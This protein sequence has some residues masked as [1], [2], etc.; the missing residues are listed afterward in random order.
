V[1]LGS[2]RHNAVPVRPCNVWTCV[3]ALRVFIKCSQDIVSAFDVA[4][5][6]IAQAGGNVYV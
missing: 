6:H 1:E 5:G 4:A 2:A 3:E